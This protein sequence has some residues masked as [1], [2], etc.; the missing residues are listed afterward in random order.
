MMYY[1]VFVSVQVGNEVAFSWGIFL[2]NGS[3]KKKLTNVVE[4]FY[5]QF[6]L[7]LFYRYIIIYCVHVTPYNDIS[8]YFLIFFSR[9]LIVKCF[10]EQVK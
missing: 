9:N 1:V 5:V 3:V 7:V 10:V 6:F 4:N 2:T 8:L